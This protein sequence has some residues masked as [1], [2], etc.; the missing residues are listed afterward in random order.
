MRIEVVKDYHGE[1]SMGA[2]GVR[3]A[4]SE[5]RDAIFRRRVRSQY[6]V[7]GR[8]DLPWRLT[9][10]PWLILVSEMMLQ[11][12]QVPRVLAVFGPFIER[13]PRPGKL[14]GAPLREVLAAWSG[15]GYNRR[16]KY[17]RETAK[18]V[19]RD[20][21]GR[22]PPEPGEL[23]RLPGIGPASAGAIAAFAF[24]RP[25]PFIET[26][27]RA[28]YLH[29]YFPGRTG[30]RDDEIMPHIERTLDRRDPRAWYY[31][32][33][34]YGAYLKRSAENPSRRS[35]HHARQAPFEGSARQARGL[36][37]RALAERPL[38]G[39]GLARLSGLSA[40]RLGAILSALEEG[41]MI[42]E[43]RGRY[44]IA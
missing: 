33:M 43:T 23:I 37:I 31:A 21:G 36:I 12:T 30:V 10:D 44:R 13:F 3:T 41:G 27:I 29:E 11:Q 42:R 24:G 8:H 25:V 7:R 34:D 35:A 39:R 1:Y 19:A 26:N 2:M 22:I 4:S 28:V 40:V 32:L 16:A 9:G 6:R 5:K 18:I 14:A 20:L 17:L 38:T 15:L